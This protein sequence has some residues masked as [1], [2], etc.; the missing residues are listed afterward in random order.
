M[1]SPSSCSR[2]TVRS[3]GPWSGLIA[4]SAE[5]RADRGVARDPQ[6]AQV[7]L[8]AAA[9]PRVDGEL[10]TGAIQIIATRLGSPLTLHARSSRRS[11]RTV[12]LASRV[13]MARRELD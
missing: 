2:S 13:R 1:E 4:I 11:S 8:G 9:A 3:F 12:D 6:E 7:R 10:P 5:H